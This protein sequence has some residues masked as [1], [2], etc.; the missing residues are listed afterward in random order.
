VK[1][2][3]RC[4]IFCNLPGLTA[5]VGERVRFHT[6]GIGSEADLHTPNW[7]G[8]VS[9]LRQGGKRT[10]SFGLLSG[11][12]QSA[13]TLAD[14]RGSWVYHCA[15]HDHQNAGMQAVYRVV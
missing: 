9:V 15:V 7:G 11:I 13:D 10:M 1:Q 12:A 2:F 5:N 3:L 4:R 14:A 6:L 8:G